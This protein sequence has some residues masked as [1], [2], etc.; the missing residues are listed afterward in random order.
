MRQVDD[1]RHILKINVGIAAHKG[2]L[3]DARQVN[4]P[5]ARFELLP[6]HIFLIQFHSR[7]LNLAAPDHLD[8]DGGRLRLIVMY[9][10]I[11]LRIPSTAKPNLVLLRTWFSGRP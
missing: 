9:L 3:L 6:C 11:I 10:F 2:H 7:S 5:H 4:S 8:H 1:A